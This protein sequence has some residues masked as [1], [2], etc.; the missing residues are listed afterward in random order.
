MSYYKDPTQNLDLL[1]LIFRTP[2]VSLVSFYHEWLASIISK[3]ACSNLLVYPYLYTFTNVCLH[4]M[5]S[6]KFYHSFSYVSSYSRTILCPVLTSWSFSRYHVIN[7]FLDLVCWLLRLYCLSCCILQFNLQ[8]RHRLIQDILQSSYSHTCNS[9][10][11][12]F[13]IGGQFHTDVGMF[14]KI[15][16]RKVGL[17][18]YLC[19]QHISYLS[20]FFK[21]KLGLF[22]MGGHSTLTFLCHTYLS[23]HQIHPV[24]YL[25]SFGS[26]F[27]L[28]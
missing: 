16:S 19:H 12:C 24:F 14:K 15:F 10:R 6:R 3:V 9:N 25:L 2:Q 4:G 18:P 17:R 26:S 1:V 7:A 13:D 28:F 22:P 11:I 20:F 5:C 21:I 27:S 23:F 8:C